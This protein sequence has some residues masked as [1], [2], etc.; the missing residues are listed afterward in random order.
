MDA[1]LEYESNDLTIKSFEQKTPYENILNAMQ[2]HTQNN[3][4]NKANPF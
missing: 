3:I 2:L 1:K 4:Q